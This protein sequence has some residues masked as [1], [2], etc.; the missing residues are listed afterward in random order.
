[1][2]TNQDISNVVAKLMP[3]RDKVDILYTSLIKPNPNFSLKT[4]EN[5]SGLVLTNNG[6]DIASFDN[7]LQV[8]QQLKGCVNGT[9]TAK[10]F[11]W[12]ICTWGGI[13][14][15]KFKPTTITNYAN[16][17][18]TSNSS[19]VFLDKIYNCM[20]SNNVASWSKVASFMYP[21]E[22][23]IYDSRVPFVLNILLGKAEYPV[24][25]PSNTI[26]K[27]YNTKPNKSPSRIQ[28]EDYCKT[29]ERIHE[30]L[31]NGTI[32][33]N[34]KYVTEMLLFSLLGCPCFIC[35]YVDK[36]NVYSVV[37][38]GTTVKSIGVG[39]V[40]GNATGNVTGSKHP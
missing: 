35:D 27:K 7:Q 10:V 21:N 12:I 30:Q 8:K 37:Q 31:Y 11:K 22:C 33:V 39:N 34:Q 17:Y 9:N 4:L 40:T 23:Y 25:T 16:M 1:M 26:F 18:D 24:P 28:Y 6:S 29:I 19:K 15:G 20:H 32:Y 5:E 2:V 38:D 13:K 3:Y 14:E 36:N